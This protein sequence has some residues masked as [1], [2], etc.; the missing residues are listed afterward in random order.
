M[1]VI[2]LMPQL[3]QT[4][5]ETRNHFHM[6][7][8]SRSLARAGVSGGQAAL[9]QAGLRTQALP[10]LGSAPLAVSSR[11]VWAPPRPAWRPERAWRRPWR[12]TWVVFMDQ[13]WSWLTTLLVRWGFSRS[14]LLT[15]RADDSLLWGCSERDVPRSLLPPPAVTTKD[16]CRHC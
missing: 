14:V 4:S 12:T 6:P 11:G 13:A 1:S 8:V 2:E 15:F 5:P 16:V 10:T 9:L 7:E 3:Q